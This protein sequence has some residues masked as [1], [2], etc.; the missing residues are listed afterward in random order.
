M[1]LQVALFAGS[2]LVLPAAWP[3][4]AA[5]PAEPAA[6]ATK[7]LH[8]LFERSWQ[9]QM[10]RGPEWTTYQGDYG[11]NDRLSDVSP[12]AEAAEYARIR[13]GL[14]EARAIPAVALGATDRVWRELFI[15]QGEERLTFEPFEG[16][17][18]LR[19]GTLFGAQNQFSGLLR[20]VPMARAEQAEQLLRRMAAYPQRMDQEIARLRRGVELGWIS[21]KPVLECVMAQ[22]DGQLP[23]D[24]DTGP[25]FA[26][27]RL[28]ACGCRTPAVTLSPA[29]CCQRCAG[30]APSWPTS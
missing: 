24:S 4:H 28:N 25:F 16:Y 23:A 15:A 17:R 20:A 10:E 11:Y 8:A 1:K 13:R 2:L 3:A 22:I 18:S 14:A 9:A 7:A 5:E 19:L 6:Q 12:A 27:P 21:P 30:C 26:P 29:R